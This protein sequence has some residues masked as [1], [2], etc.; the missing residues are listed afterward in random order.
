MDYNNSNDYNDSNEPKDLNDY[1]ELSLEELYINL[2]LISKIEVGNKLIINEQ[3][4]TID[5]SYFGFIYR[6]YYYNMNREKILKY[7]TY[8]YNLCFS[9]LN[10]NEFNE[11]DRVINY[12]NLGLNGLNNIKQ[13]YSDDKLVQAKIDVIIENINININKYK[14]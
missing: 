2:S 9:I 3:F 1:P 6:K 12:L 13:T 10:K 5:N 4:I 7:I 11:K 14:N 8:I